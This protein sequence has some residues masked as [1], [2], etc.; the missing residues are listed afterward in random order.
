MRYPQALADFV[1]GRMKELNDL[2]TYEVAK[3]SGGRI[4]NGTV[5]NIANGRVRSV[6]D[7]TLRALSR[8]LQVSEEEL[9]TVAYGGAPKNDKDAVEQTLLMK[10]RQLPPQWQKDLIGI[11]DLLYREHVHPAIDVSAKKKG[12]KRRAA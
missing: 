3:R 10:F 4:S 7:D 12:Q 1:R 8:A 5:W 11:L 9:F 6:K 2:S